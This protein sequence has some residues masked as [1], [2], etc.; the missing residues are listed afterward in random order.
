[1]KII[2]L[3]QHAAKTIPAGNTEVPQKDFKFSLFATKFGT[4]NT[5]PT[6]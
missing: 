4:G 6:L 1:M 3:S 2:K 5:C